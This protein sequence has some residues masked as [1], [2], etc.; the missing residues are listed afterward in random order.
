MTMPPEFRGIFTV[1]KIVLLWEVN[2][3]IF[4]HI[5]HWQIR[6]IEISR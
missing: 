1:V 3:M 5:Q 2:A 4:I 6:F